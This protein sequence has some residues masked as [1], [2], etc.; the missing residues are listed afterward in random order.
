MFSAIA[1]LAFIAPWQIPFLCLMQGTGPV[2][3]FSPFCWVIHHFHTLHLPL[4]KGLWLYTCGQ[5]CG[6]REV[7]ANL[8]QPI[9]Q[10]RV[11]TIHF[12]LNSAF[13]LSSFNLFLMVFNKTRHNGMFIKNKWLM[14]VPIWPH[15]EHRSGPLSSSGHP[16]PPSVRPL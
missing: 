12:T 16:F 1:L 10:K 15:R 4:H 13:S 11:L 2:I 9:N 3:S 6:F 14:I 8:T 7:L 5:F